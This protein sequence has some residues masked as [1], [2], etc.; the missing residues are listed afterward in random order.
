LV[1]RRLVI[2]LANGNG[3]SSTCGR[4]VSLYAIS[5][6]TAASGS[7]LVDLAVSGTFQTSHFQRLDQVSIGSRPPD[8]PAN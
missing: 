1:D 3:T 6:Y 8:Y 7:I 5:E 4:L 2:A